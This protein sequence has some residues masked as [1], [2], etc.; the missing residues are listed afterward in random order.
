MPYVSAQARL[1]TAERLR[2][3]MRRLFFSNAGIDWCL[4]NASGKALSFVDELFMQEVSRRDES[5]RVNMIRQA[6]F[7]SMKTIDEFDLS[8]VKLPQSLSKEALL[9][10]EFIGRKHSLIMYGACGTGKTALSVCLGMLACERGYRVK[11]VTLSQLALRLRAA[12][13]EG[14]LENYLQG[15]RKLDLLIIDEWGYT[16]VDKECAGYLFQVV[17]D[18]YERK[19]L[20]VTTNLPFREWGRIVAD[21]QLAAAIIDRLVHYGHSIDTGTQDWRL[22]HSPMN[23]ETFNGGDTARQQVTLRPM[24]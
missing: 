17:A 14:R 21:E 10:L 5:R 6:G 2:G 4:G 20:I 3:N 9:G 24:A 15:L 11:F 19:S 18:S 22:S 12:E 7:P 8:R 16:L 13:R 1:E 23:G